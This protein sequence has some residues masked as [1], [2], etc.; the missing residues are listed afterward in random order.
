[1]EITKTQVTK[2]SLGGQAT[3]IK[4]RKLA[5]DSYYANPNTCSFCGKI[6][7]VKDS[8]KIPEVRRKKFCNQ[9]CNGN[10]KKVVKDINSKREKTRIKRGQIERKIYEDEISI[11]NKT[12]G[13]LFN[14]ASNWQS[15]RS[16]I[17][18]SARKIYFNNFNSKKCCAKDCNYDIHIDV[19]H[20]RSVSNFPDDCT[21]GQINEIHNLIGLCKNHH[22]EFDHNY[23]QLSDIDFSKR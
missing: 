18:K 8:E 22:W 19:A 11:L 16:C 17:Q 20:I 23:L 7:E 13:E 14:N 3:A 5:L 15:A 10:S 2:Q 12:K 1:M 21:V 4:S 6:I 9:V